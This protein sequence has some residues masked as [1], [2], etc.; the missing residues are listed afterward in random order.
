MLSEHA[1]KNSGISIQKSKGRA[2]KSWNLIL[3]LYYS[4]LIVG[5]QSGGA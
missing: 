2:T 1:L 3:K 5:A 4:T